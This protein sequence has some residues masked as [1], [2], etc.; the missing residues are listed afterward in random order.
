MGHLNRFDPV[1][2]LHQLAGGGV[3]ISEVALF[4]F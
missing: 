4:D 2:D 3:R 1:G